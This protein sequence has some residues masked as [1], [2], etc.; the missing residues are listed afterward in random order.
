MDE[1]HAEI[2]IPAFGDPEQC[3]FPSRGMLTGHEPEPGGELTPILE[4]RRIA[5]GRDE[6]CGS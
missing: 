2:P 6:C 3:R 4:P 5:P 1:E